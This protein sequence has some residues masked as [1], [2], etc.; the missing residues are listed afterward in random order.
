MK[1]RHFR[2]LQHKKEKRVGKVERISFSFHKKNQI[3]IIICRRKGSKSAEPEGRTKKSRADNSRPS[4]PEG[5][6]PTSLSPPS[7][8]SPVVR[9]RPRNAAFRAVIRNDPALSRSSDSTCGSRSLSNLISEQQGEGRRRRTTAFET[10]GKVQSYL[11]REAVPSEPGKRANFKRRFGYL[12]FPAVALSEETEGSGERVG[13]EEKDDRRRRMRRCCCCRR[14][15]SPKE[16]FL[17]T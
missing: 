11:G 10:R 14:F 17:K 15:S 3:F 6:V 7:G 13:Q 2:H 1:K 8:G 12:A 16:D 4:F 9:S 5:R